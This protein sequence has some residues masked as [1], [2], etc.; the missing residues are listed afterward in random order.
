M[1]TIP[2]REQRAFQGIIAAATV[3]TDSHPSCAWRRRP[4]GDMGAI[5][6]EVRFDGRLCVA[7]VS[8]EGLI[9]E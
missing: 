8:P 4:F 1:L 9:S 5:D 7:P 3:T 6:G 2:F